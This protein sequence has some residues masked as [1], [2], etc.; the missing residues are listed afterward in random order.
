M[1]D[2]APVIKP[3]KVKEYTFKQSKYK[4]V[5]LARVALEKASFYRI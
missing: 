5:S 4:Q 1:S 2:K 3:I